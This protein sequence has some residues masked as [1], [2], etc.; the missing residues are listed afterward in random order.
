M[1]SS[2]IYALTSWIGS[3][4]GLLW[5]LLRDYGM[6]CSQ[7]VFSVVAGILSGGGREELLH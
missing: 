1:D 5:K 7:L 6:I 2:W 4:G 3:G